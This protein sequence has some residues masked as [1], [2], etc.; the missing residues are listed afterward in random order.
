[1][2]T[3]FFQNLISYKNS[4]AK[5]EFGQL[6]LICVGVFLVGLLGTYAVLGIVLKKQNSSSQSVKN[7]NNLF[8]TVKSEPETKKQQFNAVLLGS[9]GEGHSGGGLT[10]SIIVVHVDSETKK[11]AIIS[12]PR[13]LYVPGNR[14]INAEVSV[15]GQ[16]S[17]KSVLQ[18]VTGLEINKYA[19]V[20]FGSLIKLIDALGGID[21]EVPK[22]FD[23]NFYPIRGLEN[24]LCGKSPEEVAA[25]HQKYSGFDLEKQFTCRY[26]H[27]HF[28]K[29]TTKV[30]GET[31]LKYARSRHGDSDFGRSER[32]FSILV[33]IVK[34]LSTQSPFKSIEDAYKTLSKL[35]KT[36]LSLDETLKLFDLYGNPDKY[37]I[38]QI[39][40]TDQNVL[41]SSKS[42]IGEYILLPRSGKN[43]FSE[44]KTYIINQIK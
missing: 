6:V 41:V 10:D 5:S 42:S 34:K 8:D 16:N 29:G 15:N 1:M 2:P 28:D 23:D 43:N 11:A 25:L 32:Q 33:G 22:T 44:I 13:D 17:M 19:S 3:N 35:V 36:D 30:N 14:K 31:A 38:T 12:V 20:D 26:E 7:Y 24:E 18:G 27:I 39:H 37:E 40:L 4:L 21:V 9:G